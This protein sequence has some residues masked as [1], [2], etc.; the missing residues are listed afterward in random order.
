MLCF[1]A[2]SLRDPSLIAD[3]VAEIALIHSFACKSI[4]KSSPVDGSGS[5]GPFSVNKTPNEFAC[6]DLAIS[7]TSTPIHDSKAQLSGPDIP[8]AQIREE[9]KLVLIVNIAL[10]SI[11]RLFAS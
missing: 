2:N 1:S 6:L 5:L 7:N 11:P 8:A 4:S 3:L 10:S 9:G